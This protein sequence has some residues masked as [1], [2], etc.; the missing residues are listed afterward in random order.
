MPDRSDELHARLEA[1]E[2][3]LRRLAGRVDSL[4]A[5]GA[6]PRPL[7]AEALPPSP[8]IRPGGSVVPEV[9]AGAEPAQGTLALVGRTLLALAGA[10]PARGGAGRRGLGAGLSRGGTG[11]LRPREV[12]R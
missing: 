7:A 3:E 5:S 2:V 8:S 4:E 9:A 6:V 10:G 11:G 12:P 1:L